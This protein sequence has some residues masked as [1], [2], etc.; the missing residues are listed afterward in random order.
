MPEKNP[1]IE[2]LIGELKPGKSESFMTNSI[3]V[4]EVLEHLLAITGPA[5]VYLM[6]FSISEAGVRSLAALADEGYL[7]RP[8]FL[9]DYTVRKNKLHLLLFANEVGTI[10]LA[11]NHAKQ[12]LIHNEAWDIVVTTS[13]NFNKI[14]RWE[15]FVIDTSLRGFGGFHEYFSRIWEESVA[16]E[17]DTD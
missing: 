2:R 17:P 7:L 12:I 11:S 9:F 15:T 6:T 10:R 3:S 5:V 1:D 14:E 13:S 4:H 8:R 16:Y